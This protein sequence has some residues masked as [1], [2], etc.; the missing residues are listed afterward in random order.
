MLEKYSFEQMKVLSETFSGLREVKEAFILISDDETR[1]K[2]EYIFDKF[3]ELKNNPEISDE[4]ITDEMV[5][6]PDYAETLEKVFLE[7]AQ[8][9][10]MNHFDLILQARNVRYIDAIIHH[11]EFYEGGLNPV[12]IEELILS[13]GN[14]AFMEECVNDKTID[15]D[16]FGRENIGDVLYKMYVK[17]I[18]DEYYDEEEFEEEYDDF[19]EF[20]DFDDELDDPIYVE[21]TLDKI[22]SRMRKEEY[23]THEEKRALKIYEGASKDNGVL[24]RDNDAYKTINSMF[25]PDIDNEIARIFDDGAMLNDNAIRNA[26]EI[27]ACTL[28]MYLTMYKYGKKMD[29][30]AH[31][32]RIDRA[33]SFPVMEERGETVSNFSTSLQDKFNETFKKAHMVLVEAEI[34]PGAVCADF[35]DILESE[36]SFS[37]EREILVAPFSPITIEDVELSKE[38]MRIRDRHGNPPERKVKMVI[39]ARENAKPLT[40][41][42]KAEKEEMYKNFNNPKIRE[43][44]AKFLKALYDRKTEMGLKLDYDYSKEHILEKIDP[45]LLQSYL[46]FKKA[47]QTI[48]RYET[49]EMALEMEQGFTVKPMSMDFMENKKPS[50]PV[51]PV[52]PFYN[53]VEVKSKE[54]ISTD[55]I[56]LDSG[57]EEKPLDLDDVIAEMSE[58]IEEMINDLPEEKQKNSDF[59]LKLDEMFFDVIDELDEL[60]KTRSV[61]EMSSAIDDLGEFIEKKKNKDK[62]DIDSRDDTGEI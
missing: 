21:D 11:P 19:G 58:T 25:F 28:N 16:E 37:N 59:D 33:A 6:I 48:Y 23:Y 40:D 4:T 26:E 53:D 13:T 22:T 54:D 24:A 41:E 49:R 27:L 46:D 20:D 5:S 18:D 42:E 7:F 39:K 29:K 52:E 57:W 3:D 9:T 10:D 62:E 47:F 1:K 56:W 35:E 34:E 31:V 30:P 55:K 38:N 17:S 43:E 36:Y 2:V 60:A 51:P 45:N 14:E 32:L 15:L 50:I 8:R 12:Q 61:T 44:A